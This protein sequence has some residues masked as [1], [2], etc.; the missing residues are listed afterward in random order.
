MQL[1]NEGERSLEEQLKRYDAQLQAAIDITK[2]G[3]EILRGMVDLTE[4]EKQIDRMQGELNYVR[5][6]DAIELGC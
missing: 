1:Y 5:G 2:Q 3:N 4:R 6:F